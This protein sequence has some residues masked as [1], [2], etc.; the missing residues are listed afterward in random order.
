MKICCL[1]ALIFMIFA[2]CT[3]QPSLPK[4]STYNVT[5]I[6][7]D[8][9]WFGT[10]KVLRLKKADMKIEDARQFNLIV[11]TDIDYAGLVDGPNPN[12]SNG[13]LDPECTAT[14]GLVIYNIPLKKGRFKISKL[15]KRS[16]QK[17]EC[18]RLGYIGN[19]GG[20]MNLYVYNGS[21]PGWIKV[22]KFDKA[23]G[24][25]EGCFAITFSQDHH[26]SLLPLRNKMPETARFTDGLFRIKI[27]DVLIR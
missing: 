3:R 14:Q 23:S 5:S 11:N 24:I 12:T 2:S 25:V 1:Y 6:L 8:S 26:S 22:T 18:A 10:G 9:V 19:S 20:M 13:C 15:D 4:N 16:Q 27:T 7:N 17:N 21:K